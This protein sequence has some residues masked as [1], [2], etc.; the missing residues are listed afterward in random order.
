[1]SQIIHTQNPATGTNANAEAIS[2]PQVIDYLAIVAK[3]ATRKATG[4]T[5]ERFTLNQSKLFSA[6][7]AEVK[8]LLGHEKLNRLP[9]DIADKISSAIVTYGEAQIA[10]I[11]PQNIISARKFLHVSTRDLQVTERVQIVGENTIALKEQLF[12][13]NLAIGQAERRLTDLQKKPNIDYDAEAKCK[14]KIAKLQLVKVHLEACIA[15]M[16]TPAKS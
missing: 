8:S 11:T 16:E 9:E 10:S 3:N 5:K 13:A 1:M 7:C 14:E 6:C 12:G 15:K 4:L 2:T